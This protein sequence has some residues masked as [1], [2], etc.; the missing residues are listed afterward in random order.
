MPSDQIVVRGAREHNLKNIDVIIPRDKLVVI[1]G[2][3]GS[4]KSS[5]AFDTIFAEG[6][7][8]YVESL[9]AYA[10]QFLGQMEKP[11]IDHID[12]LSPAISIDQKS[13]SHNPR[14]TVGT[15]TEI[16]D[17]MR[18]LFARVGLPHCPQC[19]RP[20]T[21]QSVDQ[22][23]D[24]V[25]AMTDGTRI[26]LLAPIVK[27]R[28]GEYRQVFEDLRKAGYV[29]ARVDGEVRDL[30][31]EI[32]LDKYKIHSID[33]VIDRL[34]IHH[35]E[36]ANGN[37]GNGVAGNGT[38]AKVAE[39]AAAYA[40]GEPAGDAPDSQRN[41][42]ADSVETAL[43]L[44][45][46]VILVSV[47]GGEERMFSEHF[48]CVYCHLSLEE[49]AP[50]SFS[51][52]NPHGACPVCT[53]LGVKLEI[54][55]DL[56]VTNPDMSVRE[57][58]I[59]PWQRMMDASSWLTTI[60]NAVEKEMGLDFSKPWRELDERAKQVLLYGT[61]ESVG[62]SYTTRQGQRRKYSAT[63]EGIIPNLERRYKEGSESA[64]EDIERYMSA[65]PCPECHGARLKPESLAVT[66]GDR[67]IVQ[68]GNYSIVQ[69]L[70]FFEALTAERKVVTLR[71]DAPAEPL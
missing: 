71:R 5:L 22:I 36:H 54:D 52:N 19:G 63:F 13:T 4:G 33:A 25:L 42:V 35:D 32:E 58:A 14:S 48:A 40:A 51:F 11:D 69:A 38:L 43:K 34:V 23:V 59:V 2:L 12:G 18:L 9:S 66:I 6:Q 61:T 28:K 45:G 68:I 10:R 47:I 44:G 26:M 24:A 8:R 50:R 20:V 37:G 41:R 21:R 64:R 60:A 1:T 53:G 65:K 39:S 7:R 27:G 31:E 55:P 30:S 67:N 57:G 29:R 17:Y 70:R 16:Y 56:I 15:V 46:G 62:F 49:L 3:S